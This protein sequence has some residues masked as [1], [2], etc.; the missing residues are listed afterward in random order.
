M[1]ADVT[2]LGITGAD[3]A[4]TGARSGQARAG[5]SR[6]AYTVA[7]AAPP[8]LT[9]ITPTSAT[10]G[11]AT[12]TLT[13]AGSNFDTGAVLLFG[14]V[15]LTTT[16][17]SATQLTAPV[18]PAATGGGA[19]VQV[20][21]R[22]GSGVPSSSKPFT[23]N[24]P[25]PPVLTTIAPSSKTVGDPTFTLTA[26]GSNFDTGA[27][28]LF[29]GSPLTTTRVSATQLTAPVTPPATGGASTVPVVVRNG[30]LAVSAA[31]TFTL[32]APAPPVLTAIAPTAA[33]LGDAAFPLTATGSAY[34]AGAVIVWNGTPLATTHLSATQ[35]SATVD[36]AGMSAGPVPVTVRNTTLAE[37]APQT[38]TVNPAPVPVLTAIFPTERNVGDVFALS[39]Y[40]STFEL[41]AV[42]LWGGAPL[43]TTHVSAAELRATVDLAGAQA[44]TVPVVVRNNRAG[45]ESAPQPFV[46]HEAVIPGQRLPVIVID[47]IASGADAT[48]R[49]LYA[50][51]SIHDQLNEVPNT[52]TFTVQG[53][54]P[55]EGAELV[56]AYGSASNMARLFAGTILR[57]T[58]IYVAAKPA[59][60]LWQVE[61]IDYTWELNRRIVVGKYTNQSASAIAAALVATWA[62]AG[63]TTAIEAN[64]PVLDEISFTNTPLMDAMTQLATR[65][66]GYASCDYFKAIGLWITPTGTPPAPLTPSHPSL[67]EFQVTRDLSQVVTRALVEGG[68][69]NAIALVPP[70][71]TR[72]PVEDTAWYL[73]GLVVAG[74]Q[75]VKY[76]GVVVGG[77]GAFIGPGVA[78]SS[79]LT[80][81]IAA[82]GSLPLGTFKYAYTWV[83]ASGETL[84]SPVKAVTVAGNGKVPN[85]TVAPTAAAESSIEGVLVANGNYRVKVTWS[86]VAAWPPTQQ[87]LA[88]PAS[89]STNAGPTKCI[90]WWADAPNGAVQCNVYRT[91]N[92]GS[93]YYA[94]SRKAVEFVNQN[95]LVNSVIGGMTDA[96]LT[97]QNIREPGSN[98]SVVVSGKSVA[99]SGISAGASGTTARKIYRSAVNGSQL[100]LLTTL[101]D[102]TTTATAAPDTAAD[103]SLGANAPTVDTS[104]LNPTSGSV[105]AGSTSITVSSVGP[106]APAG[107]AMVANQ[108]VRYTGVSATA[109]TGVPATG[110]GALTTSVNFGRE[111][112][113]APQ[114]VGIPASGAGAIKYDILPGDAVN[115]LVILDDPGAQQ[116]LAAL[117]GGDGVVEEYQ[118]DRRVSLDEAAARA[119]ALLDLKSAVLE[120][121]RYRSRDP[122]TRTGTTITVDL[123]APTDV[124]GTY[125]IQ[126]VT[127]GGFMGTDEYPFYDVTASSRRFTFEDLLRRRRSAT[128]TD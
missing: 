98:T 107:W 42:I 49:V 15:A 62:P 46:V 115:V 18:T 82:G 73:A 38:F 20:V 71:E 22:N 48:R 57:V 67:Q 93:T 6:S 8:V 69:V 81:A 39:A 79:A 83:T 128:T 14:G 89:S 4:L 55:L 45:T 13:A 124:H 123:P 53:A 120:T 44:G 28:L 3:P 61:G 78:P 126:D 121:Y 97:A 68:G 95:E 85:P 92:N 77:V 31:Q 12:F 90:R 112:L 11:G 74:P 24:A 30:T 76:T 88:T 60:V 10:V 99:L 36:L 26:T 84:P 72:I 47:G 86:T 91:V 19:T 105:L 35:L 23:L 5:A 110:A 106:F 58:Q 118:Q 127:I 64:L 33:N 2:P 104:G 7:A 114:L 116:A 113:V 25:A 122:V 1:P 32:N 40:G 119:Q 56:I 65:I 87:T 75:R 66:G 27:V 17:V 80:A 37:S 108:V 70:G 111:I 50:T 9:S 100:K 43:T 103:A 101:N 52:C 41:D 51:L 96:Q 16:R 54:R 21:V 34:D 59:N 29:G 109:L 117:L 94:E 125:E 63:F 102:N